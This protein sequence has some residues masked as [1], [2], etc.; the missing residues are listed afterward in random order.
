MKR[1]LALLL[2]G[3][4]VLSAVPA[5]TIFAT[6]G[7]L[8]LTDA[9]LT[10][11]EKN[12]TGTAT[13][14]IGDGVEVLPAGSAFGF[15]LV[16]AKLTKDSESK[17]TMDGSQSAIQWDEPGTSNVYSITKNGTTG[18]NVD[19][20]SV[21]SGN[22]QLDGKTTPAEK[23]T[24]SFSYEVIDE[25]KP[26]YI[27]VT[28]TNVNTFAGK[29]IQLSK[30][31]GTKPVTGKVTRKATQTTLSKATGASV[32]FT[33]DVK[34]AF[35]PGDQY[36]IVLPSGYEFGDIGDAMVITGSDNN[37]V[38][39][40]AKDWHVAYDSDT[41]LGHRAITFEVPANYEDDDNMFGSNFAI[42][43]LEILNKNAKEGDVTV[44]FNKNGSS[45][46]TGTIAT[47]GSY[48]VVGT[49]NEDETIPTIV[50]G[51]SAAED[52]LEGFRYNNTSRAD[53]L[54]LG[55]GVNAYD[56]KSA[57][58]TA[59][60]TITE[61]M[62]NAFRGGDLVLTLPEG[63]EV[64][65][66]KV[67]DV[68]DDHTLSAGYGTNVDRTTYDI[69]TEQTTAEAK[70]YVKNTTFTSTPSSN[71]YENIDVVDNVVTFK[72]VQS[73]DIT[74]KFKFEVTLEIQTDANFSG[75]VTAVLSSSTN[76]V[77]VIEPVNIGTIAKVESRV[78]LDTKTSEVLVGYTSQPAAD[79]KI[80]EKVAGEFEEDETFV[81]SLE[82]TVYSNS[83][84]GFNSAK[85]SAEN[86]V[87]TYIIGNGTI[88]ITLE[89]I[90][91]PTKPVTINVTDVKV[92]SNAAVP[93][94]NAEGDAIQLIITSDNSFE[95]DSVFTRTA[96]DYIKFVNIINTENANSLYNQD[97]T[98]ELGATQATLADGTKVD[99]YG[100][101][102]IS[103]DGN[104]MMPVKGTGYA[105]GLQPEDI[106]YDGEAKMATFFLP[107]DKIAQITAGSSYAVIDGVKVP[108]LDAKGN[109][110]SPV[111][112]D[113][114]F[115]L[116]LRAASKT[117]FGVDTDFDAATKAV[118]LNPTTD[119]TLTSK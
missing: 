108:L 96:V 94:Y 55:D 114:R 52:D 2:A 38:T 7:E 12:T 24:F 45:I 98:V 88:E 43:G 57:N 67:E 111:I 61:S 109:L 15:T 42:S 73:N 1:K 59:T 99:L 60:F 41:K 87:I 51:Q 17:L 107:G 93:T 82:D 118:T 37:S 89:D 91:D 5:T 35:V 104:T 97:V 46:G 81:L 86:A 105:L 29:Q 10:T 116:P 53:V 54:V 90:I 3:T 80:A 18:M 62:A 40:T 47:F 77:D 70:D 20:G 34:D 117:V 64:T 106:V 113:G 6:N 25:D 31:V 44:T 95:A 49:I 74:K 13:I 102:Y 30:P 19:T 28:N 33:S 76:S 78:G 21:E 72:D 9:M 50:A 79:I 85:V 83:A 58:T 32:A 110:V 27:E 48:K 119:A 84:Y 23:V 65:G 75:D 26:A 56:E 100:A 69:E 11:D 8:R 16:N 39:T 115:Y 22:N 63:V 71:V 112:K 66:V 103:A 101:S 14:V 92:W 4:M 36:S 68:S